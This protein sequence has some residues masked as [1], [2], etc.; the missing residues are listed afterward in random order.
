MHFRTLL[1]SRI[2]NNLKSVFKRLNSARVKI[3]HSHYEAVII[4]FFLLVH[5]LLR[6]G[7]CL[8]LY[9]DPGQNVLWNLIIGR[10]QRWNQLIHPLNTFSHPFVLLLQNS[11]TGGGLENAKPQQ[12]ERF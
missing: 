8:P 4:F 6:R 9:S 10:Q 2:Q 12:E 11:T 7:L 5:S 1:K 3:N